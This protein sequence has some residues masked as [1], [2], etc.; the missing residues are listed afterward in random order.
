MTGNPLGV[1]LEQ[2][3][4]ELVDATSQPPFLYQLPPEEGRKAVDSVQDSPIEKPAR[5]GSRSRAA[6]PDRCGPA[7]SNRK[8]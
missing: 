8:G 6:R 1:S 5:S 7:S 2:A 4:Q 3:A